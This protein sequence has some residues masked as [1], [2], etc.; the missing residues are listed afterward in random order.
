MYVCACK[1]TVRPRVECLQHLVGCVVAV[2]TSVALTLPPAKE[3]RTSQ[4]HER[5][6][7]WHTHTNITVYCYTARRLPVVQRKEP[8]TTCNIH[9]HCLNDICKRFSENSV[10]RINDRFSYKNMVAMNNDLCNIKHVW[11]KPCSISYLQFFEQLKVM[12]SN[13]QIYKLWPPTKVLQRKYRAEFSKIDSLY[14]VAL[15]LER[16][17]DFL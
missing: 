12:L 1:S 4:L 6:Q 8:Y 17:E 9:L 10:L 13:L 14:L 16:E 15:V 5:R 7:A 2:A 11:N 3:V